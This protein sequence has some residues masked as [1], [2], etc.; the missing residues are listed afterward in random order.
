VLPCILTG[1]EIS[2]EL[3]QAVQA[4]VTLKITGAPIWS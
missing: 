2:A 1:L 4:N 3:E